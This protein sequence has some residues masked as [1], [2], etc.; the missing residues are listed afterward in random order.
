MWI[1]L[2]VWLSLAAP[3]GTTPVERGLAAFRNRDFAAAEQ[4]FLEAVRERP[5]SAMCWKLLGMVYAAQ[6]QYRKAE[7]PFRH[8]CA[9]DP[10]EEN[11]CYYLGRAYYYL[12]RYQDSR[13]AYETALANTS[14]RARPLGGLA[15]DM[16]AVGDAA[17]AEK[18]YREAISSGDKQILT[19]YGLF[20]FKQ[21]RGA[22]SLAILRRAGATE[23]I[24]RVTRELANAPAARAAGAVT[25]V[26]FESTQLDMIV[27]NG[28]TGE[29]H[30]V[31]TMIAG[32]A[33]LDYD[34]DGW[35]DIFVANG[36]PI[37]SLRKTDASYFNRLFRNNHDGTFRDVTAQAGVAGT[38]YSMGVAAADYD[39]DGYVDL[40]VTGVRGNTLYHN[41]GDGTFEDVTGRA[42]LAGDSGWTVGAGWFDYDN[43]GRLDLFVVRYVVW[44]P[45]R[46]LYCGAPQQGFR[47]YCNPNLYQPL[48]NALYRN[49]GDGRFR[50]VSVES[51]IAAHPGKGMGMAFGDY[52][53][54]GRLDVFVGNDL[55]PN[56]LFHNEGG[57]RFREVALAAGVAYNVD[58]Q[59]ISAMGADLRDYDNDGRED[60]YLTA[61]TNETFPLFRNVG[62]RFVDVTATSRMATGSLPWSGWG[63]GMF[64]FNNDGFKDLFSANGNV[65][66]NAEMTSNRKS[67]QPN[68]VFLNRGDGT[69]EPQ[70]LPG[71]AL[72]RG[73][74]FGDFNRDGR[75]DV[76]VT[77]LNEAPIVLRNVTPG[78]GHWLELRLVGTRSNRDGIGTRLHLVTAAGEQWNR[79]TTAV[80]YACSSDRLVHFGLGRETKVQVIEVEWP[81]GARQRVEDLNADQFREIREPKE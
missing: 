46:E 3:A 66:D 75:M 12:N 4:A 54:D 39:N 76:V 8:A 62:G 80:G 16:E 15:L 73:A 6:E 45:A 18:Y 77:R 56:F 33:V 55:V 53:G 25:P 10:R 65:M 14:D 21:G 20:L 35:P 27:R 2:L 43:D 42:G 34:N 7:E 38:G 37:P 19:D 57:G 17:A 67:R 74:A 71:E 9:L 79:V 58:G 51:G 5:R 1:A 50:D 22:E 63:N 47:T 30:L 64:D 52:D 29:K 36:A 68:A 24:E 49:E 59:P 28:A 61:L 78:A 69:F 72:H 44:D 13:K 70:L 11:A 26:R 48:P 32:V 40:F 41:R 23:E 81:S 60:L 31:E